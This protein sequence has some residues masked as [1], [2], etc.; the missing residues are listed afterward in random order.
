MKTLNFSLSR[1]RKG[2]T[3]IS[4]HNFLPGFSTALKTSGF[5]FVRAREDSKRKELL[6]ESFLSTVSVFKMKSKEI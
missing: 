6:N 4:F 5:E 1:K 2:A 3:A